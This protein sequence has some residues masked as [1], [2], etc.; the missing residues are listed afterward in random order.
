MLYPI[1]FILATFGILVLV[2]RRAF[3]LGPAVADHGI[4]VAL[5]VG[6][7]KES[8]VALAHE[9][10]EALF[11]ERKYF[12]AERWYKEVIRLN[13]RDDRAWTRLGVIAVTQKRYSAGIEALRKSIAINN[14][15]SSRY[16]NL[17]LAYFLL[18]DKAHAQES[19]KQALELAPE[20]ANY[21]ELRSRIQDLSDS[22]G[23]N[24]KSK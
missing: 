9:R 2:L 5:E 1:I 8:E 17:A 10:A 11:A 14:K 16:Y 4:K 6:D 22:K 24:E 20:R 19:I 23:T 3:W 21:Q 12:A 13:A 18:N 7:V 15:V